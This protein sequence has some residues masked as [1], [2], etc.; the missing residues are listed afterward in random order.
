MRGAQARAPSGGRQAVLHVQILT[1]PFHKW[2]L[3]FGFPANHF[4][5]AARWGVRGRFGGSI[6]IHRIEDGEPLLG[7]KLA[8]LSTPS[9][10]CVFSDPRGCDSLLRRFATRN[11]R[12]SRVGCVHT[13]QRCHRRCAPG[14]LRCRIPRAGPLIRNHFP[15]DRSGV[16]FRR[17]RR[18]FSE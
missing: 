8:L 1:S 13:T 4:P 16:R 15:R 10:G 2:S 18:F 14:P 7:N 17:R 3:R 6:Q 12:R 11:R 5:C 9:R